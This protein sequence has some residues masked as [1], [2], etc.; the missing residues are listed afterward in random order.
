LNKIIIIII[1]KESSIT[2][3]N[4]DSEAGGFNPSVKKTDMSTSQLMTPSAKSIGNI[5]IRPFKNQVKDMWFLQFM[6][7]NDTTSCD[8]GNTHMQ[9][10][11]FELNQFIPI[12]K[13]QY[14]EVKS[15]RL[16]EH[17]PRLNNSGFGRVRNHNLPEFWEKAHTD[18]LKAQLL[19]LQQLVELMLE[20]I[21]ELEF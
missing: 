18:Y 2:K 19:S 10:S 21:N 6:K 7:Q 1:R 20:E 8:S 15:C 16:N 9:V 3:R 11:T 4:R 12:L 5:R 14:K 13:D 17:L